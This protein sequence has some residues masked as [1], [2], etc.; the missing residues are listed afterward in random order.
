MKKLF[1][2]LL[3][4]AINIVVA[5]EI[6]VNFN[7]STDQ[8]T[9]PTTID[10]NVTI[11]GVVAGEPAFLKVT[12]TETGYRKLKF[13]N[14][15]YNL[16]SPKISVIHTGNEYLEITLRDPNANIDWNKMRIRPE[17]TGS[18][19]LAEYANVAGGIS[20]EWTS[21]SIP[22]SDFSTDIDF[23]SISFM[24]FPY[25]ADAGAFE[26]HIS[27]VAFNGGSQPYLW[28]GETKLDNIHDGTG[29]TYRML[30]ETIEAV[31]VENSIEKVEI[32]VNQEVFL[33]DLSIPYEFNL[34]FNESGTYNIQALV[35]YLD[36][37]QNSSIS[38]PIFVEDIPIPDLSCAIVNPLS[39][40]I[41]E[42]GSTLEIITETYGAQ[43]NEPTY[44][45]VL[46]TSGGYSK[47]KMSY[48]PNYVYGERQNTIA[49][50]STQLEITMR[51]PSGFNNWSKIRLRPNS[52]GTLN[53]Q[54]YVE[55]V[56]GISEE[57]KTIVIPLSDFSSSVDFSSLQ[58]MEFPY[59]ADAGYFII[60]ILKIE[61]TGGSS[62][63]LW[64]GDDKTDNM[65]DGNGGAGQLNASL[66]EATYSETAIEK[67]EFYI[68]NT[69]MGEDY[70]SPF[71]LEYQ[72]DSDGVYSLHSK[73]F[74]FNGMEAS[75]PI[76]QI[77]T[78]PP[79]NPVSPVTTSLLVPSSEDS[80]LAHEPLNLILN[81]DGIQEESL[82]YLNVWNTETGYRKLKLGY[83][84]VYI[85]SGHQNVIAGGQTHLEI[86]F[87]AF[88]NGIPWDKIRIR[89]SGLGLLNLAPYLETY[90]DDWTLVSIPLSDF[91]AG[92]NFTDLSFFEFPYSANA[93]A[94]N[95]GIRSIKFTGGNSDFVWFDETRN[96]NAHD[97]TGGSGRIFAEIYTPDPEAV[98][99]LQTT[100]II[101]NE[102]VSVQPQMC[103]A[104]THIFNQTGTY[105]IAFE[106]LDSDSLIARSIDY[107]VYVY[108]EDY[109]GLSRI[110]V[111][112]NADPSTI[113][114]QLAPLKYNKDFAY[115]LTLDDGKFDT[116]DYA[117]KLFQGGMIEEMNE[118]SD[119]LFY[120]DGCGNDVPFTASIALNSVNSSFS[121]IHINTPDYLTWS[122]IL[123]MQQAGWD[124]INHSYSHAAYG[125]T[126]Y[127]FQIQ[128]NQLYVQNQ[129]GIEMNHFVIPSGDLNYIAPAFQENM[130]AV[131]SNKITFSGYPSGI[132]ID[133][134]YETHQQQ[135][136]RRFLYD[137]LFDTTNITEKIN[138][139]AGNAGVNN[140]LWFS[141]FTHRIWNQSTG[142]SLI[143]PTFKYY[144][145]YMANQ[146]GKNGADNFWFAGTEEVMDYL[147]IREHT[148]IEYTIEG[149][150]VNIYLDL[151]EVP[152]DLAHYELSL[153]VNT[154]QEILEVAPE[155]T[156]EFVYNPQSGLINLKWTANNMKN[157]SFA[158]NDAPETAIINNSLS[159]YP[160]P[161]STG[162]IQFELRVENEEPIQLEM[163]NLFGQI[164]ITKNI[165]VSIL[166]EHYQL[167]LNDH[168]IAPG[169]YV[170]RMI[171]NGNLL[172]NQKVEFK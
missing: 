17:A 150:I 76:V 56:G 170:I 79:A 172:G 133:A 103:D 27:K 1:L 57:W 144:M 42:S 46:N 29:A 126:D 97:G 122:E 60:D 118:F 70:Y 83:D 69:L 129:I 45:S 149:N 3:I 104:F 95:V 51:A 159:L 24:E 171:Q 19:C 5:Q 120:T 48:D 25:S 75:S 105:Q 18:L 152:L 71:K 35:T 138:Q 16:Y 134:P 49:F 89:P 140:H 59:S 58:L 4:L 146:F 73:A 47:L 93:G 125:E 108:E 67:V 117:F 2:P 77:T 23:N 121:D 155:F 142:G 52:I 62:N 21:I 9:A 33:S 124:I 148:Q 14:N 13:G 119:G 22:L 115:S 169:L 43:V 86:E 31:P 44:L 116:Y 20:E 7:E 127:L 147:S 96:N 53:L 65:H 113:D 55:A 72:F 132:D 123:E 111:I 94:F 101:D 167:D 50:G 100:L 166:Q 141:E 6:T 63:F 160:N 10:L 41:Y 28:F 98:S 37:T 64:F 163:V 88:S 114:I 40:S 99:V 131:Y 92:I 168:N 158:W 102:I 130:M 112:L 151:S 34:S 143:W 66:I 110:E 11:E 61:F 8:L 78:V 38:Y 87:K 90:P 54:S 26:L 128:Q 107:P 84:E 162:I 137:G 82:P 161:N 106:T 156:N 109:S 15:S 136:Y 68:D 145:N 135:I 36:G 39:D 74:L 30:A 91:D 153:V 157:M 12:N 164:V 32:L 85:Y 154:D 139:I 165:N 80:V 81:Y